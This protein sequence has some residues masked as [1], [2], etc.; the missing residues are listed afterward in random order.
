[1]DE[2]KEMLYDEIHARVG[3][4]KRSNNLEKLLLYI[5]DSILPEEI[6][7]RE[8]KIKELKATAYNLANDIINS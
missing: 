4:I 2:L 6:G 7:D 1:M 5:I 3:D 8:E